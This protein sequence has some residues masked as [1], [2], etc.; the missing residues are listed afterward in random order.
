MGWRYFVIAMGG[1]ALI[2]FALRF[3]A[4]TIYESPKYLMGKGKDEEAVQVVHE[5]ARR[6]GKTV[7]LTLDDLRACEPEGYVAATNAGDAVRR[8]L[9]SLNFEHVTGM[10]STPRMAYSTSLIMLIWALIGLGYP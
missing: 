3:L 1:L 4:F 7:N 9:Q 5:V 8:K 10:F 2:S 6:N